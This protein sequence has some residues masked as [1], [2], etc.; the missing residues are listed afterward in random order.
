MTVIRTTDSLFYN[1]HLYVVICT[2]DFVL[3]KIRNYGIIVV[4][5]IY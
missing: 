5:I 2:L 4:F 3:L 1:R